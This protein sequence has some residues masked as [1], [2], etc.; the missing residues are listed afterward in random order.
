MIKTNP[1]SFKLANMRLRE[2]L[3]IIKEN[4]DGLILKTEKIGQNYRIN[5]VRFFINSL[6]NLNEVDIFKKNLIR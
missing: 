4:Q 1:D 3:Q 2:I 5:N 6:K